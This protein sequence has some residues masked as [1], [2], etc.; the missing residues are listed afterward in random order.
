MTHL[1]L[2]YEHFILQ[3]LEVL[4]HYFEKFLSCPTYYI[5]FP[6]T[7][8]A[9]PASLSLENQ[10]FAAIWICKNLAIIRIY[11]FKFSYIYDLSQSVI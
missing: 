8:F 5:L 3:I 1:S 11:S 7:L 10:D 9:K 6:K 4:Q 2:F